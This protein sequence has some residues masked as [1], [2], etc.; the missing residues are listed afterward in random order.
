MRKF[1]VLG[2]D[3]DQRQTTFDYVIAGNEDAAKILVTDAREDFSGC[4]E[5][6]IGFTVRDFLTEAKHLRAVRQLPHEVADLR[7]QLRGEL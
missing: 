6:V 2:Y 4:W 3:T 7:A 5:P 1:L